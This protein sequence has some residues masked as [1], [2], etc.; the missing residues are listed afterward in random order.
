MLQLEGA[1]VLSAFRHRRLL[2]Q[3]RRRVP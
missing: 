2:E 1:A 3:L